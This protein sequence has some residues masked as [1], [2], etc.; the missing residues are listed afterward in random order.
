MTNKP[1][2]LCCHCGNDAPHSK[3]F[4]HTAKLLYEEIETQRFM[5]PFNFDFYVCDTCGGPT[6]CGNFRHE[7]RNLPVRPRLFPRGPSLVPPMHMVAE[8]NPIPTDVVSTYTKAWP[9]LKKNPSAFANQIRRGL[10]HICNDQGATGKTLFA[11]LKDLATKGV[12]PTTVSD[13]AGQIR[14]VGNTG[15]HASDTDVDIWD[16]ELLDDFFRMVV[17]YVY[18]TP[19]KIKRM[20]QR[21]KRPVT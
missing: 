5:E 13:L 15:S 10:E 17:E 9:L 19:A 11:K 12:F 3:A 20:E 6:L 16:A 4:S 18:V 21:T 8:K 1:I 14:L 7:G 2:F